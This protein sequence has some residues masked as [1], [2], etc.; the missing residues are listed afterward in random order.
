[1]WPGSE[2]ACPCCKQAGHDSHTCPCK[3]ALKQ[4]KRCF[5]HST[6]VPAVSST[7][8]TTLLPSSSLTAILATADTVDMDEDTLTS[9]PISFPF[10]LTPEQVH[11]LNTL[12]A[13]QWL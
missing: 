1:M 6:P 9:D 3:P 5:T 10:Q 7:T 12:S 4:K 13:E 8:T 11:W 2:K